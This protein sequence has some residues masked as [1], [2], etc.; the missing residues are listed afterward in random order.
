MSL[1]FGYS[2]ML[3]SA[4]SHGVDVRNNLGAM[5]ANLG[6]YRITREVGRG[7]SAV[8]YQAQPRSTD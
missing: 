5:G 2:I 6:G 4:F 3:F 8:V 1:I 7:G